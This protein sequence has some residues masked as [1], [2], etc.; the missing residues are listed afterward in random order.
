MPVPAPVTIATLPCP[1]MVTFPRG[2]AARLRGL[3]HLKRGEKGFLRYLHLPDLP[4]AL[5]ALLLLLEE[6]ALA[7]DVAAVALG[8]D[9]LAEGLDGLARHDLAA[10]CGLDGD[11]VHLPRD[12]L[13]QLLA[14]AAAAALGH[15]AVD[16]HR[17][18]VHPVAV[19]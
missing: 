13:L 1:V 19:D 2:A 9:V 16:D 6:L 14:H 10:D 11:L 7:G 18:A 3:A 8:D 12:Q 15:R 4:H 17:E 5:L